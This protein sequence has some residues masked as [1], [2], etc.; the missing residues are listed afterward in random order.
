VA[1]QFSNDHSRV[2]IGKN[3]VKQIHAKRIHATDATFSGL[4][5]LLTACQS[6]IVLGDRVVAN[7]R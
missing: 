1:T 4:Q 3:D 7:D 2:M 5:S 6:R